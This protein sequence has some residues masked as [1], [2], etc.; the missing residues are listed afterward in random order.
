MWTW[1]NETLLWFRSNFSNK[2][3]FA[4]FVVIIIGMMIRT[5]HIGLTGIIRELSLMDSAYPAILHFFKAESWG[6]ASL[7]YSWVQTIM[8]QGMEYRVNGMGVLTGDGVKQA[9]EGRYMP[10]VVKL[11]QESENSSKGE[12]IFGHMFGGVGI[13]VGDVYKKL[14][15]VLASLTLHEGVDAIEA[16]YEEE[17]SEEASHVVKMI[18]D[19]GKVASQIGQSILLL[20]RLYLTVPMLKELM[21]RPLLVAVTKAKSN[22]VA[23]HVPTPRTGKGAKRKK[24]D[25]VK[26]FDLFETK[27]DEFITEAVYAYGKLQKAS[28]YSIDLL[29][30]KTLY[31]K[32]RFV[33]TILDGKKSI[34]VSTCLDLSPVQVIELYCC[35]F[36]IECSFRE[37]KQVVAGFSYRFW[38]KHMTKLSK[39]KSNGYNRDKLKAIT[40]EIAQDNINATVRAING[41]VMLSVIALGLLQIISIKF[42]DCF[43]GNSIR[44][45]RTKSNIIPSEATVADYLRKN[46]YRLFRFFPDLAITAIIKDRQSVPDESQ[47]S[48]IA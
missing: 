33:L 20:D 2:W 39:Y 37:L 41:F 47:T 38:S 27:T 34:L 45:M 32:L 46:I 42:A 31:Q 13:M 26:L 4:W 22:A 9:K 1:L 48:L 14:Y 23:F 43:T 6:V 44:F 17:T 25:K 29:W 35:R 10:G 7:A 16:W 19:A 15:C 18:R 8:A 28:Y 12:Y 40:D 3:A 21:L 36:K 30:G 24:G 11:H 5:D